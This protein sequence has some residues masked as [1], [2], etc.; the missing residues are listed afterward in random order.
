MLFIAA[1]LQVINGMQWMTWG[2]MAN[3]AEAVFGWSDPIISLIGGIGAILMIP[4][5]LPVSWFIERLGNVTC[6]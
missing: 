2:P 5:A 6:F 4:L 1:A 3:T